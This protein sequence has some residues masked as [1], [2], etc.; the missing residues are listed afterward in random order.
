MKLTHVDEN[1]VKMVEVGQKDVVFRRAIAKGRIKLK[2][3]TIKLIQEGKTK[4]G[5]VIASAQIA[6]ILAV[7]R[8]WEL[9]PLCHPIPLTGVDINFEFGED[10]I[11]ATCEVRAYYKTGVEME[12]LTGV[13]VALL[14]VW[15]MVKAVE[16]D[17][18]G[19]YPFTKIENIRVI[20]KVKK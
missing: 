5:N 9:I 16:K 15:D 14:T 13:S 12:A 17:E 6:G 4:K 20:E 19:Q 7:K 2:P 1:G 10:Y 3:E 8:T 18:K 11:E